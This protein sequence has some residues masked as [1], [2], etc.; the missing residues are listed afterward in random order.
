[1]FGSAISRNS[2]LLAGF[3]VLTTGIIA[4]TYLGTSDR[5]AAAERA[6]EEKALFQIV[7]PT[8]HDNELLED[9][10][11]VG[12]QDSLLRLKKGKRVFIARQGGEAIAAIIPVNAPDGY[13]GNIELI[14]GVNRDGSVAGVRALQHRET[15]GLGDKVDIKKS[16]WVLDFEGRGLGTPPLEQWTVKKDGG[17]FDQFTG[18]TITP[19]AV[20]M[21]VRRGLE[22][23]EANRERLLADRVESDSEVAQT[24]AAEREPTMA[25]ANT[26]AG[27]QDRG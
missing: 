21:A 5:I 19:R 23:F 22:Y 26:D 6:A 10:I 24:P 8:R 7:P 1:M 16:D 14:I 25:H 4:G 20:V 18:A 17:V 15:P 12:P 9:T 11:P 13:S 2:L 27:G 3:A